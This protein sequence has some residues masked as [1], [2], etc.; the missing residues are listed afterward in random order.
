M[1][2]LNPIEQLHQR[3]VQGTPGLSRLGGLE[4]CELGMLSTP[5]D[6]VCRGTCKPVGRVLTKHDK[7]F[8]KPSNP[9]AKR[10]FERLQRAASL[11]GSVAGF[12][13]PA[14]EGVPGYE[15]WYTVQKAC[16][17]AYDRLYKEGAGTAAENPLLKKPA[18]SQGLD[19]IVGYPEEIA[20]KLEAHGEG[21]GLKSGVQPPS[22]GGARPKPAP[23]KEEK[24]EAPPT[25]PVAAG[26]G[27]PGWL[28]PLAAGGGIFL[29]LR[30]MSKKKSV[31]GIDD[32]DECPCTKRARS[33]R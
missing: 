1:R 5:G 32:V 3:A 14:I 28:L 19:F 33:R 26:M 22:G 10:N 25:P 31:D 15:T 6:F 9:V 20:E 23:K 18:F 24:K 2:W 16:K 29:L 30:S 27:L 17:Y 8:C 13:G 21:W 4:V 7:C 12:A 11:Y